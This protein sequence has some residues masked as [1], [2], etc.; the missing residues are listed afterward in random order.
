MYFVSFDVSE[1]TLR[2]RSETFSNAPGNSCCVDF[3]LVRMVH[4]IVKSI[5]LRIVKIFLGKS[6]VCSHSLH[7]E[8]RHPH[9]TNMLYIYIHICE[10]PKQTGGSCVIQP[11]ISN[12]KYSWGPGGLCCSFARGLSHTHV[13]HKKCPGKS[14]RVENSVYPAPNY[15]AH[16][17]GFDWNSGLAMIWWPDESTIFMD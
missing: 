11:T 14:H 5:K 9:V 15:V 1:A 4:I 7:D 17:F 13:F 8:R 10:W 3:A 2:N 6:L 16:L 12:H